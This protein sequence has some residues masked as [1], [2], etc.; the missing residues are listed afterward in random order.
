MKIKSCIVYSLVGLMTA[1]ILC[2]PLSDGFCGDPPWRIEFDE[3]CA[4]TSDTMALSR[5]ELQTLITKCEHLQKAIEQL[6]ESTRKVFLKRVLMCKN[7]YQYVLDTKNSAPE[8][9]AR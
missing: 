2:A 1:L 7:L 9:V 6:D 8:Q 5:E 4:S 3:A